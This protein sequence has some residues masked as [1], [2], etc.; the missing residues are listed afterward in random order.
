MGS[1]TT[2]L[3]DLTPLHLVRDLTGN[4]PREGGLV[5]FPVQ[6]A[7]FDRRPA[8][9]AFHRPAR[10]C[11]RA[12]GLWLVR[13]PARGLRKKAHVGGGRARFAGSGVAMPRSISPMSRTL[14]GFTSTL[15]DGAMA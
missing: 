15:S 14:T 10:Q 8:A 2:T 7:R 12:L 13:R 9:T 4:V 3:H 1:F 11:Q 6:L 5:T